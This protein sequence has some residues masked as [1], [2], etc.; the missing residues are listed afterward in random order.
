MTAEG[1]ADEHRTIAARTPRV[2]PMSQDTPTTSTTRTL[3]G[4]DY[5]FLWA[6]AGIALTEIWAGGLVAASA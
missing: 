4:L 6:G 3:N 2:D 1:S 5:F